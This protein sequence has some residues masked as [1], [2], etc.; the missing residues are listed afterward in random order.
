M[1]APGDNRS[2][3]RGE[4]Y[5]YV[6]NSTSTPWVKDWVQLDGPNVCNS[7]ASIPLGCGS[8]TLL[9][10]APKGSKWDVFAYVELEGEIVGTGKAT[11]SA[12]L[13]YL[14]YSGLA[15]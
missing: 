13:G 8:M 1:P 2:G 4:K 11:I 12:S 3:R 7:N 14:E 5:G 10:S 15:S 6:D 9:V